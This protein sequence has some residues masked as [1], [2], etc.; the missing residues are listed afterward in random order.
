MEAEREGERIGR[1]HPTVHIS[2]PM[3]TAGADVYLQPPRTLLRPVPFLLPF[4]NSL[5]PP[6]PLP[7][8][9]RHAASDAVDLALKLAAV[10]AALEAQAT[11]DN[12]LPAGQVWDACV[13]NGHAGTD[14]RGMYRGT[15]AVCLSVGE[16]G[17]EGGLMWE[18][19]VHLFGLARRPGRT[20]GQAVHHGFG[21]GGGAGA[22]P[23]HACMTGGEHLLPLG[24][25]RMRWWLRRVVGGTGSN[26]KDRHTHLLSLAGGIGGGDAELLAQL[27][28]EQAARLQAAMVQPVSLRHGGLQALDINSF[29]QV[30][31]TRGHIAFKCVCA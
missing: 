29:P 25:G 18:R 10:K 28:D 4:S 27:M 2:P 23:A 7:A 1:S 3:K 30:V 6:P 17:G 24:P 20:S 21:R 22:R 15:L 9:V 11:E 31:T 5:Q 14:C 12:D 13:N 16:G 19:R 8:P 26:G